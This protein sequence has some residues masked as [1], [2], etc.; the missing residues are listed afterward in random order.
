[1][2]QNAEEIPLD[3]QWIQW[4]KLYAY[5]GRALLGD[6]V[7]MMTIKVADYLERQAQDMRRRAEKMETAAKVLRAGAPK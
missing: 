4:E 6:H 5:V 1:M 2:S 3:Y 7:P